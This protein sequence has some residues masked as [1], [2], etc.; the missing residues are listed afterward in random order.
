MSSVRAK[1]PSCL[2]RPSAAF[3]RGGRGFSLLE[4]MMAASLLLLLL[5]L[6]VQIIVP[7]GKGSVRGAQQ[8]EL[9]QLAAMT[10]QRLTRDLEMA[11]PGGIACQPGDPVVLALHRLMDVGG[12][13]S[14]IYSDQVDLYWW[15][16]RD[17]VLRHRAQGPVSRS[18]VSLPP[19]PAALLSGP[20]ARV[21]AAQVS[22]LELTLRPTAVVI[23][24]ALEAPAPD[25]KPPERFS[26]DRTV[27][28]RN[29]DYRGFHRITR[30]RSETGRMALG[31]T[32]ITSGSEVVP[33]SGWS[34]SRPATMAEEM[35]LGGGNSLKPLYAM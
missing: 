18:R 21:I 14:Q 25:G 27:Y 1:H 10:L 5:A 15:S 12:D 19:D 11:G 26:L 34:L 3:A 28:L 20:N 31:S 4:I 17:R 29:Q 2:E 7:M 32:V 13:G 16:P 24:L 35:S 23:H 8:V 30:A 6:V 33:G 9:Q 22:E